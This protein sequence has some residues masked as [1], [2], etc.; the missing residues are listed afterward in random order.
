[1]KN[2]ALWVCLA[3]VCLLNTLTSSEFTSLVS[4]LGPKGPKT[5]AKI[6]SFA[7]KL[8]N[9]KN[10][11]NVWL[12]IVQKQK[13]ASQRSYSDIYIWTIFVS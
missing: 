1:M 5:K 2:S 3:W 11:D 9:N 8:S 12:L 13:L 4:A 10:A 6:S 7:G